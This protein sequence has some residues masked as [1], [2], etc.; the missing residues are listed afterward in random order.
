MR[1]D[2][3]TRALV[4]R[5]QVNVQANFNESMDNATQKVLQAINTDAC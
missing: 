3:Q 4:K 2:E 1:V 5:K